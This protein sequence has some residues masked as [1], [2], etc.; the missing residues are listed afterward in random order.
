M[1]PIEDRIP[2]TIIDPY[3]NLSLANSII[4]YLEN[5]YKEDKFILT[6]AGFIKKT[7]SNVGYRWSIDMQGSSSVVE[8]MARLKEGFCRIQ[9]RNKPLSKEAPM[10]GSKA[11]RTLYKYCPQIASKIELD[12]KQNEIWKFKAKSFYNGEPGIDCFLGIPSGAEHFSGLELNNCVCSLD[13]HWAFPAALA[14]VMPET[15]DA[16]IELYKKRKQD[17]TIKSI[18][19]HAIGAM[20][21]DVTRRIS[22]LGLVNKSLAHLRYD[23][24]KQHMNKV[25]ILTKELRKQG[26]IILNIRTDSIKFIWDKSLKPRLP[27]EG[28]GLGEWSYDFYK[29]ARYRQFSTGCYQYEDSEGKHYVI[30]NGKTKLDKIKPRD[31]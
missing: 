15:E 24:L 10:W 2:I 26:A 1:N 22:Q 7:A 20:A 19:T 30:L 8:I 29:I 6:K 13:I 23:I 31:E 11:L 5:N 25:A 4:E 16:L 9:F 28:S 21:S 18:G 12:E 14:V 17:E 3:E 27:F